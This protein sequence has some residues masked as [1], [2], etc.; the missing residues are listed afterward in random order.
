MRTCE[1]C[2]TQNDDSRIFCLNCGG[3]LPTLTSA[4]SKAGGKAAEASGGSA[5]PALPKRKGGGRKIRP[6]D[7]SGRS[8]PGLL[9]SAL[10]TSTVIAVSLACIVQGL[11]APSGLPER[12]PPNQAV[13]QAQFDLLHFY[14][15]SE[16]PLDAG[17][18]A[19][20]VNT[21][22]LAAVEPVAT[23]NVSWLGAKFQRA[24][25]IYGEG[26]F[27]FVIEQKSLGH[28]IFYTLRMAP[29]GT[30]GALGVRTVGA[31]I[32]RMPIHPMLLPLVHPIFE[33]MLASLT[34]ATE[35]LQKAK[36]V[37][38]TPKIATFSWSGSKNP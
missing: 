23:T 7:G 10:I 32:G 37:V 19:S 16:Y 24:F 18:E 1:H 31:S 28:P 9:F 34:Q 22:L 3:R 17:I 29:D 35:L 21:Y 5:A 25:V 6:A 30:P 13:A 27:D 15:G 33:S 8:V 20:A 36:G 14:L 26:A 12:K 2:G 11:R 4:N 38:I